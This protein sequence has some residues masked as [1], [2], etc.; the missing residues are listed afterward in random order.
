MKSCFYLIFFFANVSIAFSQPGA[1]SGSVIDMDG[2]PLPFAAVQF[3]N[4]NVGTSTT[5][6]GNFHIPEIEEGIKILEISTLGYKRYSTSVNVIAG[7]N[8]HITA[9]L[10]VGMLAIDEIVVIGTRMAKRQTDS[11]V[12]VNLINIKKLEQIVATNLS[13][14]LGYQT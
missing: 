4:S 2:N 3:V 5:L 7:Q 8:T 9:R 13:D 10:E 12:I 6:E 14:G 11:P 1:L